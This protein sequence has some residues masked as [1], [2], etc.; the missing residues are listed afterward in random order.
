MKKKDLKDIIRESAGIEKKVV[1]EAYVATPKKYVLNTDM[2]LG[3]TKQAHLA[4]YQASVEALNN[5]SAKLDASD[6]EG[7]DSKS[8]EFRSL[9]ADECN[10]INCVHLHELFFA[11]IADSFS[12]ITQDSLAYMRLAKTWGTFDEWQKDFIA[13][14]NSARGDGW[15]VCAYST[16][17]KSFINIYLDGNDKNAL[18]GCI[19]LIVLDVSDHASRDYK[20]GRKDYVFAMMKEFNWAIIEDR[21]QRVDQAAKFL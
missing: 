4:Q 15:V 8:S 5:I 10:L 1:N 12:E 16:F 3:K 13:C 2:M 11:N 6:K 17:L 18:V 21:F 19:P 20:N 7:A 9:K 14:S